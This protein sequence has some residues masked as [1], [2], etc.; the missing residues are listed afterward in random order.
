[1]LEYYDGGGSRKPGKR[2]LANND[3][4]TGEVA[5]TFSHNYEMVNTY[6]A[7][8]RKDMTFEHGTGQRGFTLSGS[9]SNWQAN[10]TGGALAALNGGTHRIS[11]QN[12]RY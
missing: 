10:G 8:P 3:R 2:L 7:G 4:R 1:M 6:L 5:Q 11:V 12:G 9:V